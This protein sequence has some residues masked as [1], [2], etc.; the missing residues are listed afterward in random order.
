MTLHN[1][2][3]LH[4]R[5]YIRTRTDRLQAHQTSTA[6]YVSPLFNPRRILSSTVLQNRLFITMSYSDDEMADIEYTVNDPG[7]LIKTGQSDQSTSEG[8]PSFLFTRETEERALRNY[9]IPTTTTFITLPAVTRLE[10]GETMHIL[11]SM[12]LS[13]F[14]QRVTRLTG[15]SI[16][17]STV[18]SLLSSCGLSARNPIS[19]SVKDVKTL[20][21]GGVPLQLKIGWEGHGSQSGPNTRSG[22]ARGVDE[23]LAELLGGMSL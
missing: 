4:S 5:T 2:F 20:L 14:C 13:E 11:R 15:H 3:C 17:L 1:P 8:S 21:S 7:A 22:G 6:V 18:E 23:V 16:L 12:P 19:V 9:S 10:S